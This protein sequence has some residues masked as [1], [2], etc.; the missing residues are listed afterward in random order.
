MGVAMMEGMMSQMVG[1]MMMEIGKESLTQHSGHGTMKMVIKSMTNDG[2]R[3]TIT[4]ESGPVMELEWQD[5]ALLVWAQGQEKMKMP[6]T[7]LSAEEAKAVLAKAEEGQR[8]RAEGPGLDAHPDV[9]IDWIMNADLDAVKKKLAEDPAFCELRTPVDLSPL[10]S[11]S[12]GQ[13]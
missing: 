6:M 13:A 7:R 5:P 2:N 4:P 8:K 12:T 11:R 10:H 9:R 3:Y 1:S